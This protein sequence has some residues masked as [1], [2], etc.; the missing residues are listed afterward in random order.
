MPGASLRISSF[1]PPPCLMV[2]FLTP[3]TQAMLK[4][5]DPLTFGSSSNPQDQPQAPHRH[6][7]ATNLFLSMQLSAARVGSH[8]GLE[9]DLSATSEP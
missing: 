3:T 4:L 5:V 2:S 8:S 6:A 7:I 9:C 1:G